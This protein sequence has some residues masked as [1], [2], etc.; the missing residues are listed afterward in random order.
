VLLLAV[1]EFAVGIEDSDGR[2]AILNRNLVFFGDVEIFVH[3]TDVDVGDEEGFAESGSDFGTVEGFVEDVA[4]EAPVAA[5]D[6]QNPFVS[7]GGGAKNVRDFLMRVDARRIDDF[8]FERL[9]ETGSGRML[10]ADEV[11]LAV[12]TIPGLGHGDVLLVG[13]ATLF[14]C[15]GELEDNDVKVG[16]LVGLLD[17]LRRNVGEALGFPG[18]PEGY[19]VGEGD[20][21]LVRAD[22]FGGG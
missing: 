10:R 12:L 22:D 21:A 8:V 6:E 14:R 4:I 2:D 7:G 16:R 17:D 11:P 18:G 9:A 13:L 20:G 19:F 5:K 15:Q 1:E 3:L